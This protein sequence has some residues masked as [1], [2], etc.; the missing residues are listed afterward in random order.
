MFDAIIRYD[1]R[2]YFNVCSKADMSQLNLPH[3][4]WI[5]YKVRACLAASFAL[6]SLEW[7]LVLSVS[8]SFHNNRQTLP[9]GPS[10]F[11]FFW[12]T[13]SAAIVALFAISGHAR[14]WG[15]N[16]V[17]VGYTGLIYRVGQKSKLLILSEY[18][19]KIEKIWGIYTENGALSGIFTWN[20]LRHNCLKILWLKAVNE[21]TAKK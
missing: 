15:P 10:A 21:I 6:G 13:Q 18:V 5:F 4:M 14:T 7:L 17:N 3:V 2:C 19:N 8:R 20:I 16:N 11:C 12:C 9:I 1:T